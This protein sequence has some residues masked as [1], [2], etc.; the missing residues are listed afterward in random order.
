MP[1]RAYLGGYT[2]GRCRRSAAEPEDE[3]A[4]RGPGHSWSHRHTRLHVAVRARPRPLRV[5]EA[6]GSLHLARRIGIP[7]SGP[8]PTADA[9]KDERSRGQVQDSWAHV[10]FPRLQFE[11]SAHDPPAAG[12]ACCFQSGKDR[13]FVGARLLALIGGVG[14]G[15]NRICWAPAMLCSL[16]A[17]IRW[18]LRSIQ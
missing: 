17:R 9:E 18:E 15:W 6:A 2:L 5:R 10:Q 7:G 8:T 1:T 3:P 11:C 16:I 12:A 14:L 4:K 13:G